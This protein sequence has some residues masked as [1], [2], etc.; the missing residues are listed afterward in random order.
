V[1]PYR[2]TKSIWVLKQSILYA[3]VTKIFV[4]KSVS[5]VSIKG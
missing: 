1:D 3:K 2:I 5:E 4:K